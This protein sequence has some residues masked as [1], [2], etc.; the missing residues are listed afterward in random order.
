MLKFYILIYFNSIFYNDV[1][2]T[3]LFTDDI[4]DFHCNHMPIF[5]S[6]RYLN[7]LLV[8][9][10]H[11][12][13]FYPRQFHQKLLQTGFPETYGMIQWITLSFVNTEV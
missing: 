1:I 7:Y 13:P 3:S 8:K 10:L 6:F 11:F 12:L 5:Y 2:N 4:C 9:N